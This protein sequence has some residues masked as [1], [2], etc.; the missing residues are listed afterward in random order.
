MQSH[1][2]DKLNLMP[3]LGFTSTPWGSRT[4][5]R[6]GYGLFYDWYSSNLY[7]QTLRVNGV[8][9]RDLLIL[10]PGYPDPLNGTEAQIL[11]RGRI[12]AT[13]DLSMPQVHQASIGVERQLT[14][15]PQRADHL[16]DASRPP[17]DSLD[18]HQRAGRVRQHGRTRR[19]ARSR[20]SSPR[21]GPIRDRLTFGGN[22]RFPQRR[23]FV[24]MNYTLGQVK[25]HADSETSLPANNLDPD[26]EWGYSRQDVRH[27][28]QGTVNVPLVLGLRANVNINAQSATPY[29]ITTGRDD[30]GDGTSNDRP[31]GVGRNTERG[32]ATFVT[33]LRVSRAFALGGQRTGGGFPGG[34]GR[35]GGPG[36][37]GSA[38]AVRRVAPAHRSARHSMRRGK[39]AALVAVAAA[40]AAIRATLRS[41]RAT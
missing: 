17:P 6:G 38:P 28:L 8:S 34:G 1:I 25:N 23:I 5:I 40:A 37:G 35:P 12:Q 21:D 11:P 18:Q 4:A 3:R 15:E 14:S 39:A 10:N 22:Y 20:S 32:T 7:D 31:A 36:G 19:S 27:R 33:N 16:S 9:V 2:D 26:A 41:M 29:T 13:P 30:N 24:N